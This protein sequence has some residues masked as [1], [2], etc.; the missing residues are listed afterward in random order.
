MDA[1]KN[2]NRY[3]SLYSRTHYTIVRLTLHPE[4]DK[5][6]IE[7]LKNERTTDY[8]RNLVRKDI[9]AETRRRKTKN[10]TDKD[11]G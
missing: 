5:D 3:N 2:K 4:K 9:K 6:V 8:V 7:K 1:K 11:A 10:T